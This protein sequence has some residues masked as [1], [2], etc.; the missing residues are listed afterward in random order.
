MKTMKCEAYGYINFVNVTEVDMQEIETM[1]DRYF[2]KN[3]NDSD[4]NNSYPTRYLVDVSV[5]FDT[6]KKA[7]RELCNRYRDKIDYL[8]ILWREEENEKH[9]SDDKER[10]SNYSRKINLLS[11]H[12]EGTLKIVMEEESWTLTS[13]REIFL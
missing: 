4:E 11:E 9:H 2:I 7:I 6:T 12:E 8:Y 1:L 5:D 3:K 10:S 13:A